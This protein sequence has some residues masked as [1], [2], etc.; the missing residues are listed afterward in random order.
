MKLIV[1]VY[2]IV[3]TMFESDQL[4][5]IV[6]RGCDGNTD[7][8]M[9]EL[10]QLTKQFQILYS[11]GTKRTKKIIEQIKK[12]DKELEKKGTSIPSNA[13]KKRKHTNDDDDDDETEEQPPTHSSRRCF[14]PSQQTKKKSSPTSWEKYTK[15][16][17]R[18][19]NIS[20]VSLRYNSN[21]A[22]TL[23]NGHCQPLIEKNIYQTP[24]LVNIS[25]KDREQV[26]QLSALLVAAAAVDR[27]KIA[28]TTT[29]TKPKTAEVTS[30]EQQMAQ[31]HQE[32]Q[33]VPSSYWPPATGTLPPP[34]TETYPN[35]YIPL[36]RTN[37]ETIFTRPSSSTIYQSQ[38]VS[39][40]QEYP[41]V[42]STPYESYPPSTVYNSNI[43]GEQ[44][45]M[46]VHPSQNFSLPPLSSLHNQP[47]PPQNSYPP[48]TEYN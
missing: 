32:P 31:H 47:P 1:V 22:A 33:A 16:S 43:V 24:P 27:N 25:Q 2:D 39:S 46:H 11:N 20:P 38:P 34:T 37:E 8:T 23:A 45:H 17:N 7:W 44:H 14:C 36:E 9:E 19:T 30:Q 29:D 10:D 13:N 5:G 42:S 35:Q 41:P 6:L 21:L 48:Y 12:I 18:G 3:T 28:E 40:Y 15:R 26:Q 4:P